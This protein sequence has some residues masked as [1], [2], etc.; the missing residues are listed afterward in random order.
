MD[1]FFV[2]LAPLVVLIY[3]YYTFTMDRDEAL[4]KLETLEV[5]SFDRL[6]RVFADPVDI[7]ISLIGF[8]ALVF[9][10]SS[11]IC[12]KTTL[13][14]LSVYKWRKIITIVIQ[15]THAKRQ[16]RVMLK[17]RKLTRNQFCFGVTLYV[18]FG[19]ALALYTIS[20]IIV[21]ARNCAPYPRCVMASN[22]WDVKAG[23][24]PCLVYS[25][26]KQVPRTWSEWVDSTDVT[27]ELN[28]LAEAGFLTTINIVNRAV[29]VLPD[30]L[31]RCVELKHMYIVM[32]GW[33][34]SSA[35]VLTCSCVSIVERSCIPICGLCLTGSRS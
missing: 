34:W 18:T 6:A 35:R 12:I 1:I 21:T 26:R 19:V 8:R 31:R 10:S 2:V 9:S 7:G 15:S 4:I 20:S 11:S 28:E 27:Q 14:L 30:T 25:N 5:G 17:R 24:C 33:L 22:Q 16:G 3:A 32:T 29:P 13:L 23:Q